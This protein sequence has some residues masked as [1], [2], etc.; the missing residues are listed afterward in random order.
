MRC[1]HMGRNRSCGGIGSTNEF[2]KTSM[3]GIEEDKDVS[4]VQNKDYDS[5]ESENRSFSC[6]ISTANRRN[7]IKTRMNRVEEEQTVAITT[8]NV[9]YP[10]EAF[11]GESRIRSCSVPMPTKHRKLIKSRMN[12][13]EEEPTLNDDY[14]D[15]AFKSKGRS[16]S[17]SSAMTT[18]KLGKTGIVVEKEDIATCSGKL[19]YTDKSCESRNR[20]RFCGVVNLMKT[21]VNKVEEEEDTITS[22][23]DMSF[24]S[25]TILPPPPTTV[26]AEITTTLD[27]TRARTMSIKEE[28]E[29]LDLSFCFS[30]SSDDEDEDEEDD[31][32]DEN[33]PFSSHR[34]HSNKLPLW[35]Q[36]AQS[37]L[38]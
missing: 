30:A 14:G 26:A 25:E 28:D 16:G 4:T 3:D 22:L 6:S 27:R 37:N 32:Y 38:R 7:L 24:E 12:R 9:D 36:E 10:D 17:C 13:V 20:S 33:G 23:S 18:C 8:L 11:D 5:F 1:M 35:M 19:N 34:H 29:E 31:E 15:E 21:R 2:L